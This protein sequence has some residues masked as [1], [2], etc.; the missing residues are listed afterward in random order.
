M[1]HLTPIQSKTAATALLLVLAALVLVGLAAPV[2]WLNQRYDTAVEDAAARL[3]RY[4]RVIGMRD[5]LQK[6][7]AEVKAL[8]ASHHF[9][10]SASPAL[11]AAE[12]QEQAKIILDENG[13]KLNSI[14]ILPHK[15]EGLY[16]QV[17]VSL[18]LTAP[19]SAVKAMLFSLES[20]RPY[21]FI[22]NLSVRAN[23]MIATRPDPANE[24]DLFVQ[25][26]LTGYALKGAQ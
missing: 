13:G 17:S 6:K 21:L 12:L 24:S 4:S 18:Q 23:N 7:A 1:T 19:L 14:Q 22:D 26:D 16:R 25:F 3:E 11:A 15:D 10:K 8:D 20:A 9:L 5:A 2:W